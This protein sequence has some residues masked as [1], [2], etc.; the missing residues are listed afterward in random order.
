MKILTFFG[1]NCQS[2]NTSTSLIKSICKESAI[3]NTNIPALKWDIGNEKSAT[4][5]Y[6]EFQKNQGSKNFE[7]SNY[8][9]FL[10]RKHSFFLGITWWYITLFLSFKKKFVGSTMSIFS[11]INIK[12]WRSC[13]WN[14]FFFLDLN[15]NL[16]K[17]HK[18]YAQVQCQLCA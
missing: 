7:V 4:T 3:S 18:Y 16:Q 6:P 11:Q 5:Q 9:L 14:F 15:K 13:Y 10:Y 12:Y 17:D 2:L 8:G 1:P